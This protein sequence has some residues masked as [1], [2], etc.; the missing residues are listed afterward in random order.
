MKKNIQDQPKPKT[1]KGLV[2]NGIIVLVALLLFTYAGFRIWFRTEINNLSQTAMEKFEGDKVE[3]L[4]TALESDSYTLEKK[5]N[6]IWALG[7][8]R[9]Q[10]ALPV[11]K[12]LYTGQECDHS[13]EVCQESLELAIST[14]EGNRVDLF[15]FK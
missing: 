13:T 8:L 5:N 7:K 15:T 1:K 6:I 12:K 14:L 2:F 4:M 11:L 10:R 3:A 9:D